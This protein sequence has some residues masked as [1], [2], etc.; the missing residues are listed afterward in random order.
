MTTWQK[1]IEYKFHDEARLEQ[2]LSTAQYGN[3][4]NQG[5]HCKEFTTIGDIILKLIL[6]LKVYDEGI[7]TPG[8]I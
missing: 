3:T 8:G 6:A 5:R 2:A 7:R 4:Y 1:L